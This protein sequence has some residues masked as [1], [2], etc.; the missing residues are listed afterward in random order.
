MADAWLSEFD[1]STDRVDRAQLPFGVLFFLMRAYKTSVPT[2]Y[3]Y[4]DSPV[5]PDPTGALSPYNPGDLSDVVIQ[6][7]YEKD[8]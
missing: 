6:L 4:W 5:E 2:G 7:V 3:V 1:A 8:D